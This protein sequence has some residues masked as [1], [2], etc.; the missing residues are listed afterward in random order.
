MG[1]HCEVSVD[2]RNEAVG[3]VDSEQ[4]VGKLNLRIWPLNRMGSID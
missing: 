3:P 1:D 4:L 2:S